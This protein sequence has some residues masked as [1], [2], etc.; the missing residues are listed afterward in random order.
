M[1]FEDYDLIWADLEAVMKKY[2]YELGILH[3]NPNDE[4]NLENT[5]TAIFSKEDS[6][7]ETD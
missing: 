5:I 7:S 1:G 3:N 4:V 6:N 2:G